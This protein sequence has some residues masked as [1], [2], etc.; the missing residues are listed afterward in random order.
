MA[1]KKKQ[2]KKSPTKKVPAFAKN[3]VGKK[4]KKKVD[5]KKNDLTQKE[6]SQREAPAFKEAPPAKKSEKSDKPKVEKSNKDTAVID[7]AVQKL[8]DKRNE[9]LEA[10]DAAN[11]GIN[12]EATSDEINAFRDARSLALTNFQGEWAEFSKLIEAELKR[13]S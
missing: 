10:V 13:T 12:D 7:E 2:V 8:L 1:T 3:R 4:E 6:R 9:F 11:E 5:E